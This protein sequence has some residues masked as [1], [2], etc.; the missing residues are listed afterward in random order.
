MVANWPSRAGDLVRVLL[1]LGEAE[2][3]QPLER[4]GLA[5][6]PPS[7]PRLA[8]MRSSLARGLGGQ[9]RSPARLDLAQVA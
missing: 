8:K 6:P 1:A 2:L 9:V 4:L 5:G 7:Q 3:A